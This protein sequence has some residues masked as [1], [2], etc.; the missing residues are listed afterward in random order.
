MAFAL[1]SSHVKF[2]GETGLIVTINVITGIYG[3]TNGASYIHEYK[4]RLSI[5]AII[6]VK[7]KH[8]L[9][10]ESNRL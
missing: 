2:N 4:G 10:S 5:C 9:V 7:G 6:W 8:T 1:N 3:K